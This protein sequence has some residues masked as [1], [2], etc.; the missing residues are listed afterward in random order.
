MIDLRRHQ[1]SSV[2]PGGGYHKMIKRESMNSGHPGAF[3]ALRELT[4]GHI[5]SQFIEPPCLPRDPKASR[6]AGILFKP[7]YESRSV[8]SLS[9]ETDYNSDKKCSQYFRYGE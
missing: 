5:K 4:S 7:P 3:A 9:T 8:I 6:W 2:A 1:P